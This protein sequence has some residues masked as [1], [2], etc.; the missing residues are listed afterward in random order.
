MIRSTAYDERMVAKT[1]WQC[2]SIAQMLPLDSITRVTNGPRKGLWSVPFYCGNCAE[3]NVASAVIEDELTRD[4]LQHISRGLVKLSWFPQ[5]STV[6]IYDGVPEQIAG[7]A[8]EVYTARDAGAQ[9][10][11]ILM[12][13]AVIEA[14][15]KDQGVTEKIMLDKKIDRLHDMGIIL[16]ATAEDAHEV[17]HIGN[18]MAHGDF[19]T[20]EVVEEDVSDVLAIMHDLIEQLYI[21]KAR[22]ERLREKREARKGGKGGKG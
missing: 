7:P 13:R 9:R 6:P 8:R 16:A 14:I 17:R 5:E 2:N 11:A 12:G 4:P 3:V 21:G 22:R 1:C 19:A 18:D 20:T 15:A 10:A